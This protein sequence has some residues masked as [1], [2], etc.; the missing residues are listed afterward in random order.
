MKEFIKRNLPDVLVEMINPI[1]FGAKRPYII[2]PIGKL[3]LSKV[4]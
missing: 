3:I 2:N 1:Y 4:K